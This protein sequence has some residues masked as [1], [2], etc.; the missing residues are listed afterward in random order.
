MPR[1]RVPGGHWSKCDFTTTAS[2]WHRQYITTPEHEEATKL[3]VEAAV[4]EVEAA[5]VSNTLDE[6]YSEAVKRE[7]AARIA[8]RQQPQQ[9]AA[10]VLAGAQAAAPIPA[11]D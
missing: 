6:P 9:P 10:I 4:C 3:V 11:A 5:W 8:A 7:I 1:V 2:L